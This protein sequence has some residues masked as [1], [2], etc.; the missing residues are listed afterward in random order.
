MASLRAVL[1]PPMI[2]TSCPLKKWPSQTAQYDKPCPNNSFSL[3]RPNSLS[4]VPVA[5]KTVLA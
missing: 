2:K 5:I 3:G 4:L 1:P